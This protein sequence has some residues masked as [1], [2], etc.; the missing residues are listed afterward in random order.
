MLFISLRLFLFFF[1]VY[2]L[3][4]ALLQAFTEMTLNLSPLIYYLQCRRR[5]LFFSNIIWH[6]IC[7]TTI[8]LLLV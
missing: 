7:F 2:N 1:L 6:F 3:C 8:N 4:V 5:I